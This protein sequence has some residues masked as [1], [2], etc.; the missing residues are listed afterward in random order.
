MTST[1]PHRGSARTI[2]FATTVAMWAIGYVAMLGPGPVLGEILF[3]LMLAALPF[4][5]ILMGRLTGRGWRGGALVGFISATINLLIIGAL[6][7]VRSHVGLV[8]VW[9]GGL[10][11]G[12]IILAATG[13][14]IGNRPEARTQAVNWS[15]AF[16]VVTAAAILLLIV[17]GGIV[18]GL[19]AGMAFPDWPQSEGHNMFLYPMAELV[20]ANAKYVEHTHRLIG[21]LVGLTSIVLAITIWSLDRRRWMRGLTIALVGV[22]GIQGLLGGTRVLAD[23]TGFAI[24]HG[25]TAQLIFA[26]FVAMTAF[27]AAAWRAETPPLAFPSGGTDRLLSVVAVSL[28]LL[29]LGIGATFR[30]LHTTGTAPAGLLAGL[31]HGHIFV[32]V[33]LYV[34]VIFVAMRAMTV[35]RTVSPVRRSGHVL[36]AATTVQ[37]IL[38]ILAFIVVP[39]AAHE[40]GQAIPLTEVV[41]TSLHQAMGALVLAMAVTLMAWMH[42]LVRADGAS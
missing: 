16:A 29:Q 11:V 9:V 12:S 42:R 40:P 17:T 33:I 2:G 34:A 18:T 30:H 39:K 24:V 27:T 23:S 32:A 41:I 8:G 36:V 1:R 38:G 37:I 28:F 22:I 26:I 7:D 4:G 20:K 31:L 14:A 15:G 19:E 35:Y 5:G 13:A 3:G 25:V 21:A 6:V 10:Y